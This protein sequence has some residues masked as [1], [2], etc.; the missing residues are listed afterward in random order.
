MEH[1]MRN[2]QI[3]AGVSV[4]TTNQ[5]GRSINDIGALWERFWSEGIPEQVAGG[6]VSH[7]FGVYHAYEGD[8]TRPFAFTAGIGVGPDAV[9]PDTLDLVRIPRGGYVRFD[10]VSGPLQQKMG[11]VWQRI[12]TSDLRRSYLYDIEEYIFSNGKD[13]PDV[14]V[15]IGIDSRER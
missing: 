5:D 7:I 9:V 13:T 8:Y 14:S 3:I 6:S 15:F 1:V 10:T 11:E 2:Q 4:R 12:W